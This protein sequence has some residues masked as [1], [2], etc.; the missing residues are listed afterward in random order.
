[1]DHV[2]WEREIMKSHKKYEMVSK[3]STD[4]LALKEIHEFVY[5]ESLKYF[6]FLM[7][8]NHF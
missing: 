3:A 1:M 8:Q 6:A 2:Q 4:L 5:S 7:F